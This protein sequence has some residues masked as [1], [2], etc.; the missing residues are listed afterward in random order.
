MPDSR[1]F[2][3][4]K[5]GNLTLSHR[6]AMC[7]LTRFRASDDHVP[8]PSV[9]EYY[10]QR[11][12][13]PG[14]LIISEGAFIS[15]AHGGYANVP[16]IYNEDQIAAWR[17]VTDAVHAKGSYIFCQL[18]ALGRTA[19]TSVAAHEGITFVSSSNI[20]VDS[21]RPAPVPL[22]KVQIRQSIQ[23]YANA[24]KNA[25]KAGFDGVELHGANGYL[26]DQFIQ[27]TCNRREDEYGGSIE[28]RS[29]FAVEVVK[30]VS[31]AIGGE[32]TGVRFSPWSTYNG[33]RMDEPIPQFADVIRRIKELSPSIAYLHLVESRIAGNADVEAS[34]KL[35]FAYDIWDRPL[36]VAGGFTA[37]SAQR[38][39]EEHPDKEIVVMFGRYFISTPDLPF[40]I[41]SG[42]ALSP[43]DR[44]TFYT[45]MAT[46]GYT[47]YP[48][49]PQFLET[50]E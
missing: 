39:V 11:A 26:I 45:P 32:R 36:L 48:F 30:A 13:V 4:L 2:Q 41:K 37:E 19:D 49:S 17:T 6:L 1:L 47:D 33:M 20:P 31:D 23:D 7:P 24:A 5:V 35:T 28:N 21:E 46:K 43:Y 25:I 27:D 44:D 22:S 16:G 18:W 3:P 42:L 8:L 38:L 34:D 50:V 10:G 14:T 9:R 12:S 15:P 40:R 29:R